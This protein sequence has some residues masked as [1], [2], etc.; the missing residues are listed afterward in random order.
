MRPGLVMFP[1]A[2][3]FAR[4]GGGEVLV[5][6][7]DEPTNVDQFT[8]YCILHRCVCAVSAGLALV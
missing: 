1:G 3:E 2:D 5:V 8:Y 4:R 7:P 6:W